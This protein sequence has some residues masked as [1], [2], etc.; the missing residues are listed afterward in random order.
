[1]ENMASSFWILIGL[2]ILTLTTTGT[3]GQQQT[4]NIDV[5]SFFAN[6]HINALDRIYAVIDATIETLQRIN[7]NSPPSTDQNSPPSTDLNSPS[8][9]V[10][11]PKFAQRLILAETK[12]TDDN[13][14]INCDPGKVITSNIT[15]VRSTYEYVIYQSIYDLS[16][17][18]LI[19]I[20][21][22]IHIFIYLYSLVAT[23]ALS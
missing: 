21:P 20:F 22:C 19:I 17:I 1:M 16:M 2:L 8:A 7:Q 5:N 11:V 12:T 18:D 3:L 6:I 13:N 10:D 4:H 15:I 14:D 23:M 9:K